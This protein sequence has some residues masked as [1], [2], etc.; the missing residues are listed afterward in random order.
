M[1]KQGAS[2]KN[3]RCG[4][5]VSRMIFIASILVYLQLT[6]RSHLQSTPPWETMHSDQWWCH[7]CNI[8]GTPVVE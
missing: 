4:Y 3:T 5:E 6:M 1:N 7:C 8:F 2:W